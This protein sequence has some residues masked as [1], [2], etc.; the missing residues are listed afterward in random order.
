MLYFYSFRSILFADDTSVFY[1]NDDI[2]V[3]YDIANRELNEVCNNG[4]NATNYR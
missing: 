1:S 2:G 3:L 4:L